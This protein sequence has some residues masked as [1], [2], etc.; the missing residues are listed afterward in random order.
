MKIVNITSD[1]IDLFFEQDELNAYTRQDLVL[2]MQAKA[3][4][5]GLDIGA[6][7]GVGMLVS[8]YESCAILRI[9]NKFNYSQDWENYNKFHSDVEQYYIGYMD[10]RLKGWRYSKK[11]NRQY[12]VLMSEDVTNLKKVTAELHINTKSMLFKTDNIYKLILNIGKL[13]KNIYILRE[14]VHVEYANQIGLN[15]LQE[16][17]KCIASNNALKIIRQFY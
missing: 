5:Q 3:K 8:S 14:Y 16:H 2:A 7:Y 17:S 1:Y 4:E 9:P 15:I 11:R 6:S 13:N 12:M 10:G